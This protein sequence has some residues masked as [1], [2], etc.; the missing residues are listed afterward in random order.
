[1]SQTRIKD[2]CIL[3]LVFVSGA[4]GLIYQVVW[5]R[6]LGILLGAQARATAIIL[7]VFLGGIA[8]GYFLFGRWTRRVGRNLF[9][10]YAII[11]IAMALW[12]ILFPQL[13]RI[14]MPLAG[15]L[16]RHFGINNLLT[17]LT[18][19]LFLIGPATIL[20]GGTLPLLTQALAQS[21]SG[22]SRV[23]GSLYAW[24][25]L[26]ACFGCLV[27]GYVLVPTL[28]LAASTVLAGFGN[29]IVS[30]VSYFVFAKSWQFDFRNTSKD[31]VSRD[32][33]TRQQTIL[34]A[35][36]FISGFCILTLE[37]ILIR[38]MSLS[39]GASNYNFTLIVSIFIL[40][41][42]FGTLVAKNIDRYGPRRLLWVQL[43]VSAGLILLYLSGSYWPYMVHVIRAS[44]R[45]HVENFF[46]FQVLIGIFYT[47][48]LIIPMSLAGLILPLCFH[49][50]KN[51][52]SRLGHHVGALY[53]INTLGCVSGAVLGGYWLYH[54][55]NLDDI[56]RFTIFLTLVAAL[57]S[58]E[59]DRAQDRWSRGQ[60]FV[61]IS[62]I[63][64]AIPL[65]FLLPTY[66][67]RAFTQPFRHPQPIENVTYAGPEEFAKYLAR[68]TQYLF[69][70]D[71]PNTSVAIGYSQENGTETSRSLF[72]NGKS[73]GN[74]RG[75]R[76]T[77]ILLGHIPGLL[78]NRLNHI[79]VIG[80]GTGMTIG[81]LLQYSEVKRVDVAEISGTLLEN[82]SAFDSY[83]HAVSKSNRVRFH[84]MDAFRLLEG[85][86]EKYDVIVSEPSNPW[87]MGIENLYT[88]EF[89]NIAERRLTDSG[90]FVQWIHTYSFN[91]EL[92][93]IVLNTLR[94]H[95]K[96]LSVFQ[97]RGGDMAILASKQPLREEN[98]ANAER[99]FGEVRADLKASGIENLAAVLGYEIVPD[100]VVDAI[101][102]GV[103]NTQR[104]ENPI[105]SNGAAKAFFAQESAQF[106]TTRKRVR[107]FFLA[108]RENSLLSKYQAFSQI[109]YPSL[110]EGTAKTYCQHTVSY[111]KTLCE[112]VS[113]FI[114]L[115]AGVEQSPF[116]RLNSDT[117]MLLHYLRTARRGKFTGEDLT[118]FSKNFDR[119]KVIYSP[120][121]LIPDSVFQQE[122]DRCMRTVSTSQDLYGDC[123]LQRIVLQNT[124]SVAPHS[125]KWT[126]KYLEWFRNLNSQSS[127]YARFNEA[128]QILRKIAEL[129]K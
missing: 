73:D 86:S 45:D 116:H 119:L 62:T 51:E 80:F 46:L 93:R 33:W 44:L 29:A 53:G 87:V 97:L 78:A 15:M 106:L 31:F 52:A 54:W 100:G 125:E 101:T 105:L 24:N 88:D 114:A 40:A 103:V 38:L 107:E 111:N 30:L 58:L 122:M 23:H 12:G 83:N 108:S 47:A 37:T 127:S 35:I 34:V 110:V 43:T 17:D 22:A 117:T 112:E 27:S 18:L 3:P 82:I 13:F 36:G 16:Y 63:F 66:D 81:S 109:A 55:F 6:Y 99:R 98:L 57:L 90:L 113:T 126:Q 102:A 91:D 123:L 11:E 9:L 74:T 26:G 25:T 59:F 121:A 70:K 129:R 104:L 71:G 32:G 128:N 89:Y 68:S 94:L 115:H 75:D 2:S 49:F 96:H 92:F 118:K 1:M 41:L 77:T 60:L 5:H 14:T 39:I 7:A 124:F 84:E 56:F 72:V 8:L 120:V 42:G 19:S 10:A 50:M 76:L 61:V 64:S 65:V 21:V 67:R 4:S 69:F 20:M 85:S 95:F 48:L 28:G 79:C